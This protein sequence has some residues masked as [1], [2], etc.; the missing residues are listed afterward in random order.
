M[1]EAFDQPRIF[2]ALNSLS[3][4]LGHDSLRPTI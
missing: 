2:S 4:V 1:R 3:D